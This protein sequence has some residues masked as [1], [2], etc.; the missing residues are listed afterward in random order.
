MRPSGRPRRGSHVCL[1]DDLIKRHGPGFL[2]ILIRMPGSGG[3]GWWIPAVARMAQK[4]AERLHA[5]MR[6]ALLRSDEWLGDATAFVGEQ[7]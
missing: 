7:E 1:D 4:R 3:S 6:S 2:R 5:R